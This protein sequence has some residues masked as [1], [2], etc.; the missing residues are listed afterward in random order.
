MKGIWGYMK[1]FKKSIG[2][3]LAGLLTVSSLTGCTSK[4]K[5]SVQDT[6]TTFISIIASD[7]TEDLNNYATPEVVNGDFVQL[8]DADALIN[9]FV[10]GSTTIE[11]TDES[12]SELDEFYSLF[13]DMIKSYSVSNINIEK[14][15]PATATATA[16]IKTYFALDVIKSESANAKK[17][18]AI[19][20]YNERNADEIAAL[21]EQGT[22]VAEAKIYNDMLRMIL[23]IYED[24]IAN[25]SEKTY[26]INLSLEKNEETGSWIVTA[27]ESYDH[28]AS[29]ILTTND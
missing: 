4:E 28:T 6:A 2:L 18:E 25:S 22:E 29:S 21:Y 10:S 27:V 8:F 12:R 19:D 13:S 14:G 17:Q 24:E 23:S 26:A 9:K 16:T 3:A 15:K 7:S 5:E 11:L 1:F 20:A